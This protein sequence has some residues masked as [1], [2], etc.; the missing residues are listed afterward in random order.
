AD[1]ARAQEPDADHPGHGEHTA[2]RGG[3]HV[4]R[5]RTRR[6]VARAELPCTRVEALEFVVAQTDTDASVEDA[7]RGRYRARVSDRAFH[8]QSDLHAVRSR[9]PVRDDGGLERDHGPPIVERSA[10][11]IRE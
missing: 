3:A 11:L 9:E 2:D 8:C 1:A 5:D 7:D 4:A 10:D 6:E